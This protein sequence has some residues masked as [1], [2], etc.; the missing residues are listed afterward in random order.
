MKSKC[1]PMKICDSC[2]KMWPS[3][4]SIAFCVVCGKEVCKCMTVGFQQKGCGDRHESEFVDML[5]K[6]GTPVF[7]CQDCI[8]HLDVAFGK[9]VDDFQRIAIVLAQ[10]LRRDDSWNGNRITQAPRPQE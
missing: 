5:E 6:H 4:E 10:T 9:S 7:C 1:I 3:R 8:R 2:G